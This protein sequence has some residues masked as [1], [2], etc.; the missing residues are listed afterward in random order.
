MTEII[1]ICIMV[2]LLYIAISIILYSFKK[3]LFDLELRISKLEQRIENYKREYKQR[4]KNINGFVIPIKDI[5]KYNINK[6]IKW[7]SEFNKKKV[8]KNEKF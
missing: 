3:C 4:F 7:L 8:N 5:E 6:V 2:A 1:V